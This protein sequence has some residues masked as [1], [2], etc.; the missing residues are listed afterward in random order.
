MLENSG[1]VS[2]VGV[3]VVL[4]A[5]SDRVPQTKYG[6]LVHRTAALRIH[7]PAFCRY[8]RSA[9]LLAEKEKRQR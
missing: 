4:L 9:L 7:H 2:A 6:V 3:A 1:T 8:L 5:A